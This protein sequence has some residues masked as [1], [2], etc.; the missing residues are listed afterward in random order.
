MRIHGSPSVG[1]DR[2]G[3][4]LATGS[5]PVCSR[6]VLRIKVGF[7]PKNT[8]ILNYFVILPDFECLVWA[9]AHGGTT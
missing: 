9:G 1:I 3:V 4:W 6:D 7:C 5:E 8:E 2:A